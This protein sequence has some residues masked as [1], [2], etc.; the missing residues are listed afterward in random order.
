[1]RHGIAHLNATRERM[2]VELNP[3]VATEGFI[4]EAVAAAEQMSRRQ[5]FIH[6]VLACGLKVLA[7]SGRLPEDVASIVAA[8]PPAGMGFSLPTELYPDPPE[9]PP[10]RISYRLQ[11]YATRSL[12]AHRYLLDVWE[13]YGKYA[14]PGTAFKAAMSEGL[15]VMASSGC[16]P[17]SVIKHVPQL[18]RVHEAARQGQ[19]PAW[20]PPYPAMAAPEPWTMHGGSFAHPAGNVDAPADNRANG[21]AN[22]Y[23]NGHAHPYTPPPAGVPD[24]PAP[25]A[26]APGPGPGRAKPDA[27]EGFRDAGGMMGLFGNDDED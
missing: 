15:F 11:V 22:E 17:P 27:D 20:P 2:S 14:K 19:R 3:K 5:D 12:P 4:V 23:A 16:L 6:A 25:A 9:G 24:R 13:A 18:R 8:R 10:E 26:A 7:S 21:Y 1:M